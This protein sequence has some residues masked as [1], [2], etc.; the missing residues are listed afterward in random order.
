MI[1]LAGDVGGTRARLAL[2]EV[3]GGRP[4]LLRDDTWESARHAGP[5]PLVRRFLE[6]GPVRPDRLRLAVAGPVEDGRVRLTNLGW[7]LDERELAEATGIADA[8]LLNDFEAVARSLAVLGPDQLATLQAGKPADD[9]PRAVLGAGTGLGQ[10]FL[11]PGPRVVPSEAAHADFA[12]ADPL[13]DALL[14][15]LRARHG[16]VS[17]ERVLSGPG[18]QAV[19]GFLRERDRGPGD[20][21]SRDPGGDAPPPEEISRR[22]LEDAD[23]LCGR[24]LDLFV[25]VYGAQAGN[26]AL[27]V[28]AAAGVYL[29]GGIAPDMLPRL[30]EG[31]FLEA[32]RDKG[33][34]RPFLERVPVHV[35]T[36]TRAGLLGAAIGG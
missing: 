34:F 11:L 27:T 18:L 28:R 14:E 16:H 7:T 15:H 36:D 13:Q 19:H 23:P 3:E 25:R 4:R 20:G 21:G 9:A 22:A 29:A 35:I 30:R 32:F 8:R 33:R 6:E 24:V 2:V 10:A 31:S 1:V 17:W 26:M 12:P 5:A